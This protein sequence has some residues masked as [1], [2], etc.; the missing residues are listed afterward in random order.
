MT[1][2]NLLKN[3]RKFSKRIENRRNCSFQAIY[4]LP[5][6][7]SKDLYCRHIKFRAFLQKGLRHKIE[8][9]FLQLFTRPQNFTMIQIESICR[10]QSRNLSW[11]VWKI[12]YEK[13][14]K[15]WL[16]AF[17]LLFSQCFK[18]LLF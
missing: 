15:C 14:R 12:S 2:S 1:I 10:E 8:R 18:T 4:P 13:R 9:K 16:L 11:E 7:F 6:V 17:F 5:I 3:G